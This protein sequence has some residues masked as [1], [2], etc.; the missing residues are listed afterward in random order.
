[1]EIGAEEI[2]V[3]VHVL[4]AIAAG[5]GHW[6][7]VGWGLSMAAVA[8]RRGAADVRPFGLGHL[9]PRWPPP[10]EVASVTERLL[11]TLCFFIEFG[12]C[13][14]CPRRTPSEFDLRRVGVVHVSRIVHL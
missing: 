5:F 7:R 1:M 6:M 12:S 4:V 8:S 2:S 9:S 13:L 3:F 14:E 11:A 10:H